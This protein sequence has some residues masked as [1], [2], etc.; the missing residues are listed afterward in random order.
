MLFLRQD[1]DRPQ[2][3]CIK[4]A[5]ASR[6]KVLTRFNRRFEQRKRHAAETLQWKGRDGTP[7]LH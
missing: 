7:N 6:P 1:G 4:T 2:Q 3:L 5:K